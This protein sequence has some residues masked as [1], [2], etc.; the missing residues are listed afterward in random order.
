MFWLVEYLWGSFVNSITKVELPRRVIIRNPRLGITLRF[1][2][3]LVVIFVCWMLTN[4][5]EYVKSEQPDPFKMGVTNFWDDSPS[6]GYNAQSVADLASPV[7]TT[8]ALYDYVYSATWRYTGYKCITP[9]KKMERMRKE[10]SSSLYVPLSYEE[11]RYRHVV[12]PSSGNC[13]GVTNPCPNGQWT[14]VSGG[15]C[16][17]AESNFYFVAGSEAFIVTFDHAYKMEF[18]EAEGVFDKTPNSEQKS[19]Y[20]CK[21]PTSGSVCDVEDAP[22]G[23]TFELR[24]IIVL[25]VGDGV[26]KLIGYYDAPQLGLKVPLKTLLDEAGLAMDGPG[27]SGPNLLHCD[28]PGAETNCNRNVQL[29]P[30]IRQTGL[31]IDINLQYSN[32]YIMPVLPC[33]DCVKDHIGPICKASIFVTP[34]WASRQDSDCAEPK[35]SAVGGADCTLRY[36]YGIQI[37]FNAA[38]S[39]GVIDPFTIILA[40]GAAIVYLSLPLII[41][42]NFTMYLLGGLSEVYFKASREEVSMQ[43]GLSAFVTRMI[44]A[45]NAF[46]SVT[47]GEEHPLTKEMLLERIQQGVDS[48]GK[49]SLD[50][51]EQVRLTEI[52]M[53]A[54]D[55]HSTGDVTMSDFMGAATRN[56]PVNL[57]NTMTLF[58]VDRKPCWLERLFTPAS[59]NHSMAV[60]SLF[61]KIKKDD[62]SESYDIE[63]IMNSVNVHRQQQREAHSAIRKKN[64]EAQEEKDKVAAI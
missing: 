9:A 21:D 39:F 17:C 8:P 23:K 50:P 2:Q 26:E 6:D 7:C 42:N 53:H 16:E 31:N 11:T 28:T 55:E 32:R 37:K 45:Q 22:S 18:K 3:V 64:S 4:N 29:M 1:L 27:A 41:M 38:G 43:A 35:D 57:K 54:I 20:S 46:K 63:S 47:G 15:V 52:V 59:W 36:N 14:A 51:E 19:D 49:D 10:D 48:S 61:K 30:T 25:D 5:S 44:M 24:T 60:A 13:A 12:A 34:A 58:D 62:G 40:L 56:D 33:T